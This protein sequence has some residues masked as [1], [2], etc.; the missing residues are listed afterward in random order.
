MTAPNGQKDRHTVDVKDLKL[1][2]ALSKYEHFARAADAC[3]IS[4]PAFSTRIRKLEEE[5]DVP[6]VE[7]GHRFGGFT[8]EGE[9]VLKWAR[10]VISNC[11]GLIQDIDTA[12]NVLSGEFVIGVVPTALPYV[13]VIV[14]RFC[15][16]HPLVK[17]TIIS[18]SSQAIQRGLDDYSL[19]AAITYLENE[20]LTG[21]LGTHLY[22]E[23]YVFVASS[24]LIEENITDITWEEAS[25]YPLCL[26][27]PNM[28][29]R[30]IIN[31]IFDKLDISPSIKIETNSFAVILGHVTTGKYASILPLLYLSS[32]GMLD[33]LHYV[34]LEEPE[35]YQSVGL[36]IADRDP[37]L[38]ITKEFLHSTEEFLKKQ[39]IPT[40]SDQLSHCIT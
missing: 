40:I 36:I 6:I 30:R 37:I 5:L 31:N 12:R 35:L 38:P 1:I 22:N 20:P 17:P 32:Y 8:H 29:N 39:T 15:D 25:K 14:S 4:Q 26:L 24:P 10:R 28:Q 19:H 34:H 23:S 18:M 3:N 13:S 9:I 11:D 21:I 7:R 27:T 33:E 2:I 16:Q